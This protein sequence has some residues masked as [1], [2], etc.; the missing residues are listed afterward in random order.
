M[1]LT[2]EQN[3]KLKGMVLSLGWQEV[4]KPLLQ[5]SGK[6]VIDMVMDPSIPREGDYKNANDDVLKGEFRAYRKMLTFFE[7]EVQV[8]E[9]NRLLDKLRQKEPEPVGGPYGANDN[10]GEPV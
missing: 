9:Q 7:N 4:A 6:V 8:Y 2:N 10:G 5:A 3:E 1:A